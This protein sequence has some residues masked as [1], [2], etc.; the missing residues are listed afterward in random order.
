MFNV[1]AIV[2]KGQ[3]TGFNLAG[4]EVRDAENIED[5]QKIL[6]AEIKDERNGVI[7]IDETYTVD[8]SPKIQKHIDESSLPIVAS[9]PIITKW[10]YVHDR[11]DIIE[12]IIQR[13]IGYRI[14]LSED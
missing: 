7:L 9:I 6:S 10:E 2:P 1:T 5:A 12:K 14:K 3:G 13:A 4:I 8:L 11:V